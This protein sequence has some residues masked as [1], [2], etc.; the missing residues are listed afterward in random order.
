MSDHDIQDDVD[1]YGWSMLSIYD[2]EP[3]FRYTV[4]LMR[5]F[6][7]PEFIVFGLDA[8]VS[9]ELLKSLIEGLTS[10]RS[11]NARNILEIRLPDAKFKLSFRLVHVTQHPLYLGYAMGFCRN[12]SLGELSAIQVFWADLRGKFPFDAGCDLEVYQR[13]PRLDVSLTL[14]EIRRWKR[15]WE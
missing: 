2:H 13:Q 9:Y 4:G 11:F 15:Q 8:D 5:T 6:H 10:G 7:Q 1:N 14:S 3:P 12:N